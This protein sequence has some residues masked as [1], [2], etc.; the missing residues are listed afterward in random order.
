MLKERGIFSKTQHHMVNINLAIL[1]LVDYYNNNRGNVDVADQICNYSIY[2]TQWHRNRELWWT[3]WCWEVQTALKFFTLFILSITNCF[4]AYMSYHTISS[5]IKLHLIGLILS[6]A[7]LNITWNLLH[8]RFQRHILEI[9]TSS[10][11]VNE[12]SMLSLIVEL[13][14]CLHFNWGRKNR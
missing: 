1:N 6:T 14:Q 4:T 8:Q 7:I 10:R 9:S 3:R 12:G 2:D 5:S 11:E 13:F